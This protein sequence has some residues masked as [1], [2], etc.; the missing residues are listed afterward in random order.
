MR[1]PRYVTGSEIF[2]LGDDL[3]AWLLLA[4]GGALVVGNVM[5]MIRPPRPAPG[6]LQVRPER[7][8]VRRS[9]TMIVVGGVVAIWA[10]ATIIKG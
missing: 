5:A 6:D 10:L 3:L 9:V 2:G 7:P 1:R 4:F 8:P